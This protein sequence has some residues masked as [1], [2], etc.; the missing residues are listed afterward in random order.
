[1]V[2]GVAVDMAVVFKVAEKAFNGVDFA[3]DGFGGVFLAVKLL[4]IVVEVVRGDQMDMFNLVHVER[5]F[6][7]LL[8]IFTIGK[9]SR[10]GSAVLFEK[11]NKG[12]MGIFEMGKAFRGNIVLICWG[13]GL[14]FHIRKQF[15][16]ARFLKTHRSVAYPIK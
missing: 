5:I 3:G 15:F 10:G 11:V 14:G 12:L 2:G 13:G 7:E 16:R 4:F 1:M 9:N 8:N 6:H